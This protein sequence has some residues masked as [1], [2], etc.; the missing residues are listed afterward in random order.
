[1]AFASPR[2]L[3]FVQ[4]A[5][6]DRHEAMWLAWPANRAEWGDALAGAQA[7][8]VGLAEAL[9]DGDRVLML[10]TDEAAEAEA[11]AALAGVEVTFVRE[12]YGD[13]WLRDTAPIGLRGADGRAGS[14]RLR[15]NGWAEKYVMAGDE[16]LA[17]R[18]Q[19][20]QGG[21][22]FTSDLV[23]EGGA[24]DTD[25]EGTLLTTRSCL[26]HPKRNPGRSVEDIE[27]ALADAF[28]AKAVLWLGDGLANDH[29]DGHVDTIARFVAPGRVVCMAPSGDDPNAEV[30]EAIA[31]AL[32]SFQDAAGRRL[33]VERIPSPGRVLGMDGAVM[34]ASHVN[35]IIGNRTV[36]VPTYGTPWGDAAVEA[37]A[38]LFPGR[39]VVGRPAK[40]ILEGG[41]AFH[42]ITQQQPEANP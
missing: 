31:E 10:V 14:V 35:F 32:V 26:L 25:G 23:A 1:M 22:A 36:V 37:L 9:A 17:E 19:A 6:W 18:L 12:R 39:R 38:P 21:D 16:D 20:R 8:T 41:G 33:A 5:E 11:R 2:S 7:E 24:F 34:P 3:G 4:P 40:H 13:V 30:L 15:F 27:V 28:G 42:C 29:T